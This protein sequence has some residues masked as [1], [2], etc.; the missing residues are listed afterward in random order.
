[1]K[2]IIFILVVL[3]CSCKP[4]TSINTVQWAD[5]YSP[6]YEKASVVQNLQ[7]EAAKPTANAGKIFAF[8]DFIFQNDIGTGIHVIDNTDKQ[9]PKKIGFI[10]ILYSTELAINGK[11][12]YANNLNDLVVFELSTTKPPVFVNRIAN[13][14]EGFVQQFPPQN[15]VYFECADTL[16]GL[17]VGWQKNKLNNPKCYH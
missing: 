9:N 10:N 3:M 7:Y 17:V 5:G 6:I 11:Y 2:T 13:V 4:K 12:L 15:N 14:F 8:G 16:K 1:M